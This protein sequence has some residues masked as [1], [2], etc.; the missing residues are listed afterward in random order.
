M[1]RPSRCTSTRAAVCGTPAL[2]AFLKTFKHDGVRP[3]GRAVAHLQPPQRLL[4]VMAVGGNT[5]G[6]NDDADVHD[7]AAVA[8]RVAGEKR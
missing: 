4:M 2:L 3:D 1:S 8:P 5:D 6:D 7:V